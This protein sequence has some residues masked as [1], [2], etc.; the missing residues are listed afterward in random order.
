MAGPALLWE[1]HTE[2]AAAAAE[3]ELPAALSE[4][5]TLPDGPLIMRCDRIDFPP[6]GVAHRHT[7]PGPGIRRLVSGSITIETDGET[8]DYGVGGCAKPLQAARASVLCLRISCARFRRAWFESGPSPVYATASKTKPSAFVRVLVLGRQW[9]GKRTITYVDPADEQ[10]PKLQKPT[11]F[12]DRPAIAPTQQPFQGIQ[13][14]WGIASLDRTDDE[15][16]AGLVAGLQRLQQS[17]LLEVDVAR[18]Y[19]EA[20]LSRAL[21]A[22]PPALADQIVINTK[23]SVRTFRPDTTLTYVKI[24]NSCMRA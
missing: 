22:A 23:A 5:I 10:K 8:T 9:T 12:F 19:G 2:E 7:H 17:G 3:R 16:T 15:P 21:L 13:L 4:Q 18:I 20:M 24:K 6:G 14:V 1:L 11:V